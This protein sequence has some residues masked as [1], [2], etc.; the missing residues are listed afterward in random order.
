MTHEPSTIM[1]QFLTTS[2]EQLSTIMNHGWPWTNHRTTMNHQPSNKHQNQNPS[3]ATTIDHQT[4]R[5]SK[6]PTIRPSPSDHQK[7]HHAQQVMTSLARP[8][9]GALSFDEFTEAPEE[10][11][12]TAAWRAPPGEGRGPKVQREWCSGGDL[13][14]PPFGAPSNY[15]NVGV[16]WVVDAC[17]YWLLIMLGDS[18]TFL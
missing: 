10:E 1:N 3:L 5:P 11:G 13:G 6:P 18:P 12:I 16:F 2:I 7:N 4:I 15:H 9:D 17:W 8:G 14:E